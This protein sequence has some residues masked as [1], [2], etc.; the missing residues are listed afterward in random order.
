MG[1]PTLLPSTVDVTSFD[2][3]LS[4]PRLAD[5]ELAAGLA[6]PRLRSGMTRFTHAERL[7]TSHCEIDGDKRIS[8][9]LSRSSE[10]LV[11]L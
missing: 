10:K 8:Q 5:R 11:R 9:H 6:C 3:A 4:A 7:P 1:V 2:L